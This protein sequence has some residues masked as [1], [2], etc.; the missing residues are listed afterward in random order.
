MR[1]TERIYQNPTRAKYGMV[2]EI[3]ITRMTFRK[4]VDSFL[5][6]NSRF[7]KQTCSA[8][9]DSSEVN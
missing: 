8:V 9:Y 6:Q 3:I 7:L 5:M 2:Y 4:F 1:E